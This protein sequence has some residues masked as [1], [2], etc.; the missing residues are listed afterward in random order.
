MIQTRVVQGA[1][2]LFLLNIFQPI[3]WSINLEATKEWWELIMESNS[4]VDYEELFFVVQ[5]RF[6]YRFVE[7]VSDKNKI[8]IKFAVI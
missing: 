7:D 6:G 3:N 1:E 5:D 2:L 4:N 8:V